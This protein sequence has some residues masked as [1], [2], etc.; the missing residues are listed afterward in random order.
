ML[1]DCVQKCNYLH[2]TSRHGF[3]APPT[4]SMCDQLCPS[5][6]GTTIT[7][8]VPAL[9]DDI[10]LIGRLIAQCFGGSGIAGCMCQFVSMLQPQWRKIANP[11]TAVG[12]KIRC[13]DRDP[14]G[15]IAV[16]IDTLII[17]F[18][19]DA[20]NTLIGGVNA[21]LDNMPVVG[22]FLGPNTIPEFCMPN[23]HI[24]DKCPKFN[25]HQA[26]FEDCEDANA[27]GG[28]DMICFYARVRAR[29]YTFTLLVTQ[30]H[31]HTHFMLR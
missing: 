20:V 21:F 19:E 13:E 1:A 31:T 10:V 8:L 28:M 22:A 7:D 2:R 23:P 6:I 9:W 17:D 11:S 25:F 27:R 15:M 26:H 30:S 12:K 4:C 5:N 14:W 29:T 3:G 18:A 24:P 16:Y